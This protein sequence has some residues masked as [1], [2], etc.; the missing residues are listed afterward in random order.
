MA[1][2]RSDWKTIL[3]TGP[4]TLYEVSAVR[5][6]LRQSLAEGKPLRIDLGDSGPWDLAGL[7]LLISCEKTARDRGQTFCL[8]NIPGVCTEIAERSG[9]SKW[10]KTVQE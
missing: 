2:E 7:Q 8:I 6:T 3:L 4:I 5:E 9:L 1:A 10:L